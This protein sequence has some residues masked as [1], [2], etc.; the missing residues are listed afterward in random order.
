[1]VHVCSCH[2][3]EV[4]GCCPWAASVMPA[5]SEE[6]GES[7]EERGKQT[8]R[9]RINHHYHHQSASPSASASA[10]SFGRGDVLEQRH[11]GLEVGLHGGVPVVRRQSWGRTATCSGCWRSS[12]Q[13][14]SARGHPGSGAS[15]WSWSSRWTTWWLPPTRGLWAFWISL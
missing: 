12:V 1:M 3:G 2:C 13:W 5:K 14:R 9:K 8:E 11:L 10:S 6:R 15:G 4:A 7:M